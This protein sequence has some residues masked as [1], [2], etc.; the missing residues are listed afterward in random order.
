MPDNTPQLMI[1]DKEKQKEE[2][3]QNK[4]IF[5]YKLYDKFSTPTILEPGLI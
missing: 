5:L 3:V 4:E 1:M 2:V